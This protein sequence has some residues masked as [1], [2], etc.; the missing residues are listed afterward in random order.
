MRQRNKSK[1]A[2][3]SLPAGYL[4][5][6]QLTRAFRF[7]V[8]AILGSAVLTLSAN[9]KVD[10]LYVNVTMQTAALFAI[11]A[12]YGSR[13]AVA[14]VALYLLEGVLGMPVFTGTPEKGVGL[15]YMMGPTGGYLLSYLVAAWMIGRAAD[16]G[17]AHK[18]LALGGVMLLAEAVV[19][20]MGAGW[21]AYLY[22]IEKGIAFGF[23]AFI[24][25]DL[26]KLALAACSVPAMLALFKR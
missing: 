13:L 2:V 11:S 24:I 12:L 6:K 1:I 25:A 20:V 23:G 22:G 5:T 3:A 10:L 4:Q 15:A 26:V 21:M 17:L 14:T 9:I 18:P 19:L 16:K 8:L 7:V